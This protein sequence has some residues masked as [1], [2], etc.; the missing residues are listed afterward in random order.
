MLSTQNQF[1]RTQNQFK[2]LFSAS[3]QPKG[4]SDEGDSVFAQAMRQ[5]KEAEAKN[6]NPESG[7]KES[8]ESDD[9]KETAAAPEPD[10]KK[11]GGIG[12]AVGLGVVATYIALG[13]RMMD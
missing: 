5:K 1:K 7:K 8:S 10:K 13:N 6:S 2:R 11:S 12:W 3:S 9:G 4:S